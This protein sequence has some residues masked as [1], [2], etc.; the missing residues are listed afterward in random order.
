MKEPDLEEEYLRATSDRE[1]IIVER[2]SMKDEVGETT[3][4]TPTE[5]TVTVPMEP[6]G[7]GLWRG[8]FSATEPGLHKVN[9]DDLSAVALVGAGNSREFSEVAATLEPLAPVA[10]AMGG[11]QFWMGGTNGAAPREM[12]RLT[13]LPSATRYYGQNWLALKDREAFVVRGVQFTPL[14]TGFLALALFI[15]LIMLTWFRESR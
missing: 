9:M 7:P 1:G 15:G 14:L 6:A 2:R 12:P 5:K 10:K 4:T 8:K 11:G 3:I 13:L